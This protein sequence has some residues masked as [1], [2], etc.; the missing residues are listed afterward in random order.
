[1]PAPIVLRNLT[2]E[3]KIVPNPPAG[4][5]VIATKAELR[6]GSRPID[7]GGNTPIPSNDGWQAELEA[8]FMIADSFDDYEDWIPVENDNYAMTDLPVRTNGADPI[9]GRFSATG[10]RAVAV[11]GASGALPSAGTASFSG[12]ASGG[13]SRN[14]TDY[15]GRQYLI[16]GNDSNPIATGETVTVGGWTATVSFIPK[17]IGNDHPVYRNRGK[18]LCINY[19]NFSGGIMGFGPSRL[20]TFFGELGN[21]LSGLRKVHLFWM[22]KFDPAFFAQNPD[23]TFP[24]PGVHKLFDLCSG[25]IGVNDWGTSAEKSQVFDDY[26]YKQEYGLNYSIIGSL[27]GGL[28]TPDRLF[29]ADNARR[30]VFNTEFQK[31]RTEEQFGGAGLRLAET[32]TATDDTDIHPPFLNNQWFGVEYAFD[33]GTLGA[34]DGSVEFWM[35][36]AVGNQMGHFLA[37]SH[38]RKAQFDHLYNLFTIGGN[39]LCTDYGL[40]PVDA[41]SRLYVDDCIINSARIGPTYFQKLSEFEGGPL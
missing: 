9:W 12:G 35:Y 26:I 3:T 20:T 27:G 33:I 22:M 1:M 14:F 24:Q 13:I 37:E 32:G 39:R 28:S 18:S 41:H 36:D 23:G 17:A 5:P 34:S 11:T 38:N 19:N 10:S 7:G 16:L 15:D 6:D 25:H 2:P 21:S 8:T 30:A 29:L 31:W 4:E 40:C